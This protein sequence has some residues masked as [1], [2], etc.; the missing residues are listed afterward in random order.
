MVDVGVQRAALEHAVAVLVGEPASTFRLEASPLAAPPPDVPPGVPSELL[1]RRSDI[2]AAERRLAS[3]FAQVGVT[4]AAYYP[5]LTLSGS[6]GF[7]SSSFGSWLA[8]ASS[9]WSVG[10]SALVNVLDFGRRRAANAQA[11]AGYDIATAAYHETVLDAF[12]EVEDQLAALRV[13]EE[14]AAIQDRAV[15]AAQR[16]LTLANNRY[17][18]G[19]ASYLEVITAQGFALAN[20]RAAV[21]LLTRRMTATVLLLKG[22][23]GDWRAASLPTVTSPNQH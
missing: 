21:N 15:A 12:R 18:G 3:A 6:A 22:L 7:E 8:M 17:R 14:E 19:V 4:Q 20:E 5:V 23:G 16:A 10:P 2:A 13:L 9:F 11:R 1:E